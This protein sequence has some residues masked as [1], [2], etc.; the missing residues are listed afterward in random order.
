MNVSARTSAGCFVRPFKILSAFDPHQ[1]ERSVTT[2]DELEV[3]PEITEPLV[4]A[5]ES[6]NGV[7][8]RGAAS[9]L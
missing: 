3:S 7:R 1:V 8:V 6:L 5:W 9:A 2:R 4:E